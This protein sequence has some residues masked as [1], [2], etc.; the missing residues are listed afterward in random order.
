M[1]QKHGYE[2]VYELRKDCCKGPGGPG[3]QNDTRGPALQDAHILANIHSSEECCEECIKD[4]N[5]IQ[6]DYGKSPIGGAVDFSKLQ[7]FIYHNKRHV[8][9]PDICE[10]Y[11][12]PQQ[13]VTDRAYEGGVI[14]CL[15]RGCLVPKKVRY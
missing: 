14:R 6:W 10:T 4:P 3:W 2:Q 11:A 9:S 1:H 5:C 8:D 15:D 7:C 13:P 12:Q